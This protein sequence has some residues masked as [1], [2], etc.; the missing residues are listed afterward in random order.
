VLMNDI[1]KSFC[2]IVKLFSCTYFYYKETLPGTFFLFVI[3]TENLNV[4]TNAIEYSKIMK[5]SN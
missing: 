5:F 4:G 1:A 2:I 3:S